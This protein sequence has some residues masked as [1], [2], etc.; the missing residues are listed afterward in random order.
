M[1]VVEL[2]RDGSFFL[3]T[4]CASKEDALEFIKQNKTNY[5]NQGSYLM[6]DED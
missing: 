3:V 1:S 5:E 6:L 4:K 2:T